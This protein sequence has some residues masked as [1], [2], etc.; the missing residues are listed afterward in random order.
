MSEGCT[1]P[2]ETAVV[3][4][5]VAYVDHRFRLA[6]EYRGEFAGAIPTRNAAGYA[7]IEG[8]IPGRRCIHTVRIP[9]KLASSTAQSMLGGQSCC[10]S[11]TSIGDAPLPCTS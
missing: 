7:T 9:F 8:T 11:A 4:K 1:L 6:I 3:L 5:Y 10:K 2:S